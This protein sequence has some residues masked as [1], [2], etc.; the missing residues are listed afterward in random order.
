MKTK[1]KVTQSYA[2][3]PYETNVVPIEMMVNSIRTGVFKKK[4]EEINA[5]KDTEKQRILKTDLPMFNCY[6]EFAKRDS[7]GI[8]ESNG[9][10]VFDLD[11]KENANIKDVKHEINS[12]Y[13]VLH[14]LLS[15][16]IVIYFISPRGGVKFGI[17]TN[18][19]TKDAFEYQQVYI[20][21]LGKMR[22]K[23]KKEG[24]K[25]K[26][27][28]FD[29][30][31]SNIA[32]GH[33][34]SYD[35]NIMYN[36]NA[37]PVE[38]DYQVLIAQNNM[39]VNYGNS[40][41]DNSK[42]DD[43]INI[44]MINEVIE[45][46]ET[47][48]NKLEIGKG[49]HHN[50]V[51]LMFAL[52]HCFNADLAKEFGIRL[53]ESQSIYDKHKFD[54][55]WK[56]EERE[57]AKPVGIGRIFNIAKNGGFEFGKKGFDL[58]DKAY[59]Q[60]ELLSIDHTN[61]DFEIN[62]YLS[63]IKD[64]L[65]DTISKNDKIQIVSDTGS[66]KTTFVIEDYASDDNKTIFLVPYK[67]LAISISENKNIPAQYG[68]SKWDIE[69][70]INKGANIIVSTYDGLKTL[71][72]KIESFSNYTLVIDEVHNIVPVY[73]YR[74]DAIRNLLS[75]GKKFKKIICLTGTPLDKDV[76]DLI[77]FF[78]NIKTVNVK[79]KKITK[80]RVQFILADNEIRSVVNLIRK[81]LKKGK[82]TAVYL[83]NCEKNT[84]LSDILTY[85]GISNMVINSTTKT[86]N[87]TIDVLTNEVLNID[88]LIGTSSIR[89]GINI[90]NIEINEV[91]IIGLHPIRDIQQF[92]NRFR[93]AVSDIDVYIHV[94][95]SESF[96]I[97]SSTPQRLFEKVSKEA[98]HYLSFFDLLSD[99]YRTTKGH[100][101]TEDVLSRLILPV[102]KYSAQSNIIH[103]YGIDN[104]N[105]SVDIDNLGVV[106]ET[107]R[108]LD[109]IETN[110]P[111]I[112]IQQFC[113]Y[114]FIYNGA[115]IVDCDETNSFQ[116]VDYWKKA[117]E[118]LT[119]ALENND[120]INNDSISNR[121]YHFLEHHVYNKS[122]LIKESIVY[123]HLVTLYERFVQLM[124][125]GY[126]EKTAF[127]IICKASKTKD[128]YYKDI[129]MP[130]IIDNLVEKEKT[131]DIPLFAEFEE[132]IKK[133]KLYFTD[134]ILSIITECEEKV[135]KY[136]KSKQPYTILSQ[137]YN[138]DVKRKRTA[139]KETTRPNTYKIIG[140]LEPEI[141]PD[142]KMSDYEFEL[143]MEKSLLNMFDVKKVA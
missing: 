98:D 30:S 83:Q 135:F 75:I 63:E 57:V 17:L 44:M 28:D 50:N 58:F 114:G 35:P 5:T 133:D 134:E 72:E 122:N 71:S 121:I 124:S 109:Q 40:N 102:S 31:T 36:P 89:D 91:H 67:S 46:F 108:Q 128:A 37:T 95:K 23:F 104:I 26:Y 69:A 13:V 100:I 43:P 94:K 7:N 113:K 33:Y 99:G 120:L 107:Q 48:E 126:K 84:D 86:D 3:K 54:K 85:Y 110:N 97:G 70:E 125:F 8:V 24:I 118:Y 79:S 127:D 76:M 47:S 136:S 93:Y 2:E 9:L 14:N 111:Y 10:F 117:I 106:W 65:A 6:G 19:F 88:V 4:V 38:I 21:M 130:L 45:F 73:H 115:M 66:G 140:Y 142:A 92:T 138:V 20:A 105:H 41:A 1:F 137:F 141:K 103:C 42:I 116:N 143:A 129:I 52:R 77:P 39:I 64:G 60:K 32:R 61:Y 78:K 81:N 101:I 132:R 119:T 74:K 25:F 12:I 56:S 34:A 27:I 68:E 11:I 112:I 82:K 29:E 55:F 16:N 22:N 90:N 15:D 131:K 139:D 87:K 51:N 123:K 80:K 59:S 18:F 53:W 62:N 96:N 49:F